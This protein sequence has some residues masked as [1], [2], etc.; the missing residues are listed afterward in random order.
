MKSSPVRKACRSSAGNPPSAAGRIPALAVAVALALALLTGC[1]TPALDAARRDFFQGRP[2]AAA[3]KLEQAA[4]PEKDQVLFL[5]ERGTMRQAC[6]QYETSSGDFVAAADRLEQLRTYSLSK[7]A[8]SLVVND[9]VQ[10][11]RG[12]PYERTLLHGMTALNHL[13][14]GHWDDGAVEARR[15][16]QSLEPESRGAYPEDAF[17]RYMAGFCLEMIDDEANAA[18]QYRQAAT[19]LSGLAVDERTGR[20]QPAAATNAPPR[21]SRAGAE[22]RV[23]PEWKHELVCFVLIGNSARMDFSRPPY[24]DGWS[25]PAYAEIRHQGVVLGRS[26]LLTDTLDLAYTTDRLEAARKMAKTVSRVVIKEVVAESVAQSTKEAWLGDLT[27]LILI[28]LLERPDLRR[29]ETLPR[30]LHVARVPCPDDLK[31][32]EVVFKNSSG[33]VMG[34][35]TVTAPLT[36]RRRLHVSF[37]RDLPTL[38]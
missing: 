9:T 35:Q 10:D 2:Q 1:A 19:L 20:L 32:F 30:W 26:Y 15:I 27:R 31:E 24:D 3:A 36:L 37:C 13:A 29:W 28:G 6:A 8:S 21:R 14:L 22:S 23:P 17:S 16:I 11:F 7:G 34:V 5:M 33:R 38:N 25:A 18:V 4:P 12:A